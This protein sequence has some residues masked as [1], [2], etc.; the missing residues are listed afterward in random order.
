[1]DREYIAF[2]SYRHLPLDMDVARRLHKR[3]EHYTVPAPYRKSGRKT[4]GVVFR[5]QDELP[6]SADLSGSIRSALDRSQFLIIIATPDWGKSVW[7]REELNYFLTKHDRDHVL[8]VLTAG[9][10]EESIPEVLLNERDGEG[11][12]IRR[13]EPLAAGIVAENDVARRI[14]LQR[15]SLRIIAALVGCAYDELRQRERK[16]QRRRKTV[17]TSVIAAAVLGFIVMLQIKNLQVQAQYEEAEANRLEAEAQRALAEEQR[18]L[19]EEQR[20]IAIEQK[21]TAQRNESIMLTRQAKA[22]INES[23]RRGEVIRMLSGALP[24]AQ[25][26]DRPYYP[27]AEQLLTEALRAYDADIPYWR[28]TIVTED[29]IVALAVSE[30]R[31]CVYTLDENDLLCA[32]SL[33]GLGQRFRVPLPGSYDFFGSRLYLSGDS[34]TLLCVYESGVLY[35]DAVDARTG[36]LL[37]SGRL[38]SLD[39]QLVCVADDCFVLAEY[40]ALVTDST[41]VAH[42]T[43]LK[44]FDLRTGALRTSPRGGT[45]AEEA[46]PCAEYTSHLDDDLS[47]Y[48]GRPEFVSAAVSGDGRYIA[49]DMYYREKQTVCLLDRTTGDIMILTELPALTVDPH[50]PRTQLAF[51]GGDRVICLSEEDEGTDL[52]VYDTQG[53]PVHEKRLARRDVAQTPMTVGGDIVMLKIGA[54]AL[55]FYDIDQEKFIASLTPKAANE[56]DRLPLDAGYMSSG[57]LMYD[58]GGDRVIGFLMALDNGRFYLMLPTALKNKSALFTGDSGVDDLFPLVGRCASDGLTQVVADGNRLTVGRYTES[59]NVFVPLPQELPVVQ[60]LLSAD[61]GALMTVQYAYPSCSP[62]CTLISVRDRSVIRSFTPDIPAK[63]LENSTVPQALALDT[64]AGRVTFLCGYSGF[65]GACAGVAVCDIRTGDTV[66]LPLQPLSEETAYRVFFN[67]SEHDPGG[68]V[69]ALGYQAQY[70]VS[71]SDAAVISVI[72]DGQVAASSVCPYPFAP[73][74]SETQCVCAGG[75]KALILTAVDGERCVLCFDASLRTWSRFSLPEETGRSGRIAGLKA[76]DAFALAAGQTLYLISAADG[77]VDGRFPLPFMG[78][79]VENMFFT[80]DDSA[81][82]LKTADEYFI[83]FMSDGAV[84]R[85]DVE[86]GAGSLTTLSAG[87]D[88]Y[89]F[90]RYGD[91]CIYDLKARG[92]K[93]RA[94]DPD[95]YIP[96]TDELVTLGTKGL[97]FA[98]HYSLTELQQLAAPYLD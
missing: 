71:V 26:P 47:A 68:N 51:A 18:A 82:L 7:C 16:Y 74:A 36:A 8:V 12:I 28:D 98:H 33:K 49:Y 57:T 52:T 53:A 81:L 66:M 97:S 10:P 15:E 3:I 83:V 31:D 56:G 95:N 86:T 76:H 72:A 22:D 91:C 45:R 40:T 37:Y 64:G 44:V 25:D 80:A 20:L 38:D 1:M 42:R 43:C 11:N 89:I 94:A 65:T 84:E 2:I 69:Y 77:H 73:G 85:L 54:E 93:T 46:Y 55:A 34:E 90:A 21:Y 96:C 70:T 63:Y 4:P 27:E 75:D 48:A 9:A 35:Y 59:R 67:D 39:G 62:V 19:A 92:I 5:D 23:G 88:L 29:D 24:G 6:L 41:T 87:D 79:S 78:G 32:Y 30:A 50:Y 13:S 14:L 60:S 17:I 61:G 58:D